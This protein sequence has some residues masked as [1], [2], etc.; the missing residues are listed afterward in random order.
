MTFFPRLEELI[1]DN[2]VECVFGGWGSGE[3][4]FVPM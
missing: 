1:R 4:L 3:V 2:C